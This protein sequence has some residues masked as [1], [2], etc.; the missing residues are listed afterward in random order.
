MTRY[1]HPDAKKTV[2]VTNKAAVAVLEAN[3]WVADSEKPARKPRQ[4]RTEE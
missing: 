1:T 2:T 3:G 4:A